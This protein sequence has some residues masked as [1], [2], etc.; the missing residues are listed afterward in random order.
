MPKICK[1]CGCYEICM[2]ANPYR[3]E[4]CNINWQ[5]IIVHCEECDYWDQNHCSDGQ[6]WCPKVVGYRSSDWFCAAG[7]KKGNK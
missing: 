3:T 4:D 5:P 7:I 6:G 1:N 2:F